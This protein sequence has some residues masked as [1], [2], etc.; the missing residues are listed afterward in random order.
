M[1]KYDKDN[2]LFYLN[3][4]STSYVIGIFE[5]E[6]LLHLYWGERLKNPLNT[7]IITQMKRRSF[8]ADDYGDYSTNDFPLEYSTFGSVDMRLPAFDAVYSDGSRI[9]KLVYA[10]HTITKGKPVLNGL[11]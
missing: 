6:V 2:Q 3:T 4:K 7:N 9:T 5:N 10:E 8:S 1:I 11:P